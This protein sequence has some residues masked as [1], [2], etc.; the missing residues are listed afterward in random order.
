MSA[1]NRRPDTIFNGSQLAP[2][3]ETPDQTLIDNTL[4]ENPNLIQAQWEHRVEFGSKLAKKIVREQ[5]EDLERMSL[6]NRWPMSG[7]EIYVKMSRDC[8]LGLGNN[9][10]NQDPEPF[11]PTTTRPGTGKFAKT[12]PAYYQMWLRSDERTRRQVTNE[13]GQFLRL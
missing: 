6:N 4:M 7:K 3:P 5:S 13:E 1:Y 11:R 8:A 9:Q 2:E 12:K 10:I